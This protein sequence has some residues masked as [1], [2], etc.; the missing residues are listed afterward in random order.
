MLIVYISGLPL[1]AAAPAKVTDL[2]TKVKGSHT[3]AGMTL[4]AAALGGKFVTVD[5]NA[6]KHDEI[7]IDLPGKQVIYATHKKTR[8][9]SNGSQ[10]WRGKIVGKLNSSAIF[11]QYGNAVAGVIRIGKKVYKLLPVEDGL[12]SIIEVSPH[13]PWPE[14]DLVLS[15]DL[16]GSGQ[17]TVPDTPVGASD[18][19]PPSDDGSV[20]DVMVVY[21]TDTKNRLGGTDGINAYI[22][23]AVAESNQAYANS[24]I[25]T[26]LNLVHTEEVANSS[27]DISTD[28]TNLTGTDDTILDEVHT[29]RDQYKADMVNYLVEAEGTCG[30][31]WLNRGDLSLDDAYGFS[32]V[33]SDCAV[34]YYTFAHELGHNMGSAHDPAHAYNVENG[35]PY[36]C[37][38]YEYSCGYQDTD[39]VFRTVMAYNC[40]NGCDRYPYFS[41]PDVSVNG[42]VTGV[43]D[44]TDNARSINNTKAAVSGWRTSQS[45]PEIH[46]EDA[47]VMLPSDDV[48]EYGGTMYPDYG[49][50]SVGMTT[51]GFRFQDVD[52]PNGATLT[53]AYLQLAAGDPSI[54]DPAAAVSLRMEAQASGNAEPFTENDYDITNRPRST[55]NV[56]WDFSAWDTIDLLHNSPDISS[57]VQ[58]IVDR[59]D[60]DSNNS[61]VLILNQS[62]VGN[63]RLA[64][65]W[66]ANGGIKLHASYTFDC[67]QNITLNDNLWSMVSLACDPG[68]LTVSDLFQGLPLNEYDTTWG[69]YEWDAANESYRLLAVDEIPVEGKGY[70]FYAEQT[71]TLSMKGK[72]NS[73]SDIPLVSVPEGRFNLVGN[74]LAQPVAWPDALIVSG[75]STYTLDEAKNANMISGKIY[76]WNGAAYQ[77]YDG[78]TPGLE[79][80]LDIF[81][82]FWVQAYQSGVSLRLPSASAADTVLD[83]QR[84][85]HREAPSPGS[86]EE[87]TDPSKD[88]WSVRLTVESG[89]LKDPGNILGQLH[90]SVDGQDIHDL[91]E[92]VPFGSTYLSIVFPHKDF[93]GDGWGFTSDFHALEKNKKDRWVFVVK[94]SEDVTEGT[95]HWK[96][97]RDILRRAVLIDTETGKRMRLKKIE[98]YRFK[99][100]NGEHKFIFKIKRG[101]HES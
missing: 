60:W 22:A 45:G 66:E 34:G 68:N 99:I 50:L 48:E 84:S 54:Y 32:V 96:G 81:D 97:P 100:K 92:K 4:P 70:W 101:K 35:D 65:A 72:N 98:N 14:T 73:G 41:N 30:I 71:T 40:T 26:E 59:N 78:T 83:S 52:I 93:E 85:L 28:L 1:M 29:L 64:K 24:E 27:G 13:E 61:M 3:P 19:L 20:I 77:T 23:T 80:T 89:S 7:R 69:L 10:V 21:S 16:S 94:A 8:I 37:G 62:T 31:A 57:I 11:S 76:Q 25:G 49:Y 75:G 15:P 95:L 47:V 79:G 53:S 87:S 43:A 67:V 39:E 17:S 18:F 55:A 46:V 42:R 33:V 5:I 91:E 44:V 36:T 38:V 86:G 90:D 88:D 56:V 2:F 6:L 63:K 58:E 74:P 51:V 82:A 12:N 9:H